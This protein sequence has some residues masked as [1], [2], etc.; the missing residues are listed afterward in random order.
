VWWAHS[1]LGRGP[2]GQGIWAYRRPLFGSVSVLGWVPDFSE[3]DLDLAIDVVDV[4]DVGP[5]YRALAVIKAAQLARSN[6]RYIVIEATDA[7]TNPV[8]ALRLALAG[9][10]SASVQ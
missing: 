1:V 5:N 6:M 9:V 4:A 10:Q 3:Y 7:L 2:E 8:A